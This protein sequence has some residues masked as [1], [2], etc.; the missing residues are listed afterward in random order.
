MNFL[1]QRQAWVDNAS[2]IGFML[3]CWVWSLNQTHQQVA[4]YADATA[5]Q[6]IG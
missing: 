5:Y 3:I 2:G 4:K 1:I 6:R